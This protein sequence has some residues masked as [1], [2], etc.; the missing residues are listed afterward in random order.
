MEWYLQ[1]LDRIRR[2]EE[3]KQQRLAEQEA[4]KDA[5]KLKRQSILKARAIASEI[6]KL[7]VE[8]RSEAIAIVEEED[9]KRREEEFAFQRAKARKLSE[10]QE[11]IANARK[12]ARLVEESMRPQTAEQLAEQARAKQL[13]R[14]VKRIKENDTRRAKEKADKAL[15]EREE[16]HQDSSYRLK[17]ND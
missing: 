16:Q 12:V 1:E 8:D 7:P 14:W 5:E 6:K 2:E 9:K 13:T 15:E 17:P 10:E 11:A 3:F 4:V